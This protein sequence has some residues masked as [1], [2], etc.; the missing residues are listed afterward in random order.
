MNLPQRKFTYILRRLLLASVLTL[1]LCTGAQA[2]SPIPDEYGL[3]SGDPVGVTDLEGKELIPCKYAKIKYIGHGLFLASGINPQDRYL[4]GSD[5]HLFNRDGVELKVRLPGEA[6]LQEVLW[7]GEA[8]DKDPDL[9]INAL[10]EETLFLFD[11]NNLRG[12]CD[13]RGIVRF[14]PGHFSI[15]AELVNEGYAVLSCPGKATW[16]PPVYSLLNLR[17]FKLTQLPENTKS[18]LSPMSEGVIILELKDTLNSL[19]FVDINGQARVRSDL[20]YAYPFWRD[21]TAIYFKTK[22]SSNSYKKAY[23]DHTLSQIS[24]QDLDIGLYYGDHAVARKTSQSPPLLG[25]I[26]RKFKFILEPTYKSLIPVLEEPL[27]NQGKDYLKAVRHAPLIYQAELPSGGSL[28]L[29]PDGKALFA[30]PFSSTPTAI[31]GILRFQPL[32]PVTSNFQ[33]I[34]INLKGEKV[35]APRYGPRSSQATYSLIAQQRLLKTLILDEGKFDP[36]YWAKH[37]SQTNRKIWFARFLKD[38]NLIGMNRAEVLALLSSD[39]YNK[40]DANTAQILTYWMGFY[41]SHDSGQLHIYFDKDRVYKWCFASK[42]E[43]FAPYFQDVVFSESAFSPGLYNS[44][45]YLDCT[46]LPKKQPQQ[47]RGNY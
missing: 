16:D 7:L 42:G 29:S 5:K 44:V 41:N 31:N 37:C 8:A 6:K 4:E 14:A 20:I 21:T 45:S 15:D 46:L 36:L 27:R 25:L 30:S 18:V 39:E 32:S 28:V 12:I 10:P 33:E 34:Y 1:T 19:A 26:D 40:H 22:N 35:D 24:P 2:N 11:A 47:S 3:F 23:V 9:E 17:D 38:Y 43:E 13:Q